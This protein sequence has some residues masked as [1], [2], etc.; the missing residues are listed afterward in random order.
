MLYVSLDISHDNSVKFLFRSISTGSVICVK[1][2]LCVR[3]WE[4]HVNHIYRY[5]N[6]LNPGGFRFVFGCTWSVWLFCIYCAYGSGLWNMCACVVSRSMWKWVFG[7]LCLLY[8]YVQTYVCK[9]IHYN[10]VP[11]VIIS[12]CIHTVH[13]CIFPLLRFPF[14]LC[15]GDLLGIVKFDRTIFSWVCPF[16]LKQKSRRILVNRSLAIHVVFLQA[17]PLYGPLT[18]LFSSFMCSYKLFTV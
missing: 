5:R 2:T 8:V 9:C 15:S 12:Q 6:I 7:K 10:C 14:V 11:V 18:S 17:C 13:M 1:C 16:S 4:I 3:K